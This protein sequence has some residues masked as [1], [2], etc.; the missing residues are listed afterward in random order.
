MTKVVSL[1]AEITNS[2]GENSTPEVPQTRSKIN[3]SKGL[4]DSCDLQRYTC[5]QASVATHCN[6]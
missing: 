3:T 2:K 5:F 6:L 4:Q 1:Y